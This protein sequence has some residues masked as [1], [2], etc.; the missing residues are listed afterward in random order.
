MI[1]TTLSNKSLSAIFDESRTAESEPIVQCVQ[2][3]P[4]APQPNGQ[5]RYRAV[6]SDISNYV[7]TMI[8]TR[9]FSELIAFMVDTDRG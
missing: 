2:I 8:A 9:E 4:L 5:E 6:F 1:C 3:K 7:Q